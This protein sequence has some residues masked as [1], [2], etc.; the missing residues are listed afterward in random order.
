MMISK[1]TEL[2]TV[3]L[4]MQHFMDLLSFRIKSMKYM[5]LLN[6][7]LTGQNKN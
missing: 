4:I 1:V 3:S 5:K 6:L 7:K 2:N